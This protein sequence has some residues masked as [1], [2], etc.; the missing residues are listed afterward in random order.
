MQVS[1]I[2][3]YY[4][5]L[6]SLKLILK[7]LE[8]QSNINFEVIISEDDNNKETIDF[9]E[10]KSSSYRFPI[11]HVN[12]DKDL[13]FRKNMTLNK[14]IK[15]SRTDFLIFIDG[16]CIPHKHF[17]KSYI[18][19]KE[20]NMMLKGRRVMLSES[21]T[22]SLLEN[23]NLK[24]LN[25]S[26]ILLSKSDKKK[27]SIY[28][29]YFSL[30][31][32]MKNKGLLGCNWG[33]SKKTLYKING[34]DEDYVRAAVG[35]DTDIEWRLKGI[36]IQSKSVKNKAIVYHLYHKKTYSKEDV[37]FNNRLLAI[38]KDK[39]SFYCKNGLVK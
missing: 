37:A 16:D 22:S 19:E 7:A 13:G 31:S 34:F 25:T 28:N 15:K 30:V 38:K 8:N 4:K 18:R 32:T 2:I 3:S 12:Q 11:L 26:N 10:N 39:K 17:I 24:L 9:I 29:P 14:S 5:N 33:I 21:I 27:E 36:D 6:N 35:E 20:D 1:L 23:F